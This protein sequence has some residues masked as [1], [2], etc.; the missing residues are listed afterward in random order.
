MEGGG[1]FA[2]DA[3]AR[4]EEGGDGGDVGVAEDAEV[5]WAGAVRGWG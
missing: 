4:A 2:S 3:K 1:D 5:V